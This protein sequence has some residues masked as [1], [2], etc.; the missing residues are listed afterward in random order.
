MVNNNHQ[1]ERALE[2]TVEVIDV[3]A[4]INNFD[5]VTT[6]PKVPLLGGTM[7]EAVA[8]PVVRHTLASELPTSRG[9]IP[10]E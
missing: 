5:D 2:H 10:E 1:L 7:D 6:D 8:A 4:T 9:R 3:D